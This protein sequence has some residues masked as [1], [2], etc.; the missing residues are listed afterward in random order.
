MVSNVVFAQAGEEI[1][2]G[3]NDNVKHI[4]IRFDHVN[5]GTTWF[6]SSSLGTIR[7]RSQ[8]D[9]PD[10]ADWVLIP[11][12]NKKEINGSSYEGYRIWNANS[13]LF[14][15]EPEKTFQS[16]WHDAEDCSYTAKSGFSYADA[17]EFWIVPSRNLVSYFGETASEKIEEGWWDGT[18]CLVTDAPGRQPNDHCSNEFA[19]L[20][21]GFVECC[22]LPIPGFSNYYFGANCLL[23][24]TESESSLLEDF[25][26][27]HAYYSAKNVEAGTVP[28]TFKAEY[29][30]AFRQVLAEAGEVLDDLDADISAANIFRI[31][32]EI[33]SSYLDM[34][35]N[36]QNPIPDGYYRFVSDAVGV[37]TSSHVSIASRDE[38]LYWKSDDVFDPSQIWSVSY[39]SNT[40]YYNV[41][42]ALTG[43]IIA[44]HGFYLP[45]TLDQ[46][47]IRHS[48]R[49]NRVDLYS[50]GIPHESY[51]GVSHYLNH[52][53]LQ[54]TWDVFKESYVDLYSDAPWQLVSVSQRELDLAL[55]QP[56]YKN[57]MNEA[58]NIVEGVHVKNGDFSEASFTR[59]ENK[60]LLQDW[61]I[62]QHTGNTTEGYMRD[63]TYTN[64]DATLSGFAEYWLGWALNNGCI[65]QTLNG[66]P[67]GTY[68]LEADMIAANEA[69]EEIHGVLLFASVDAK[70]FE[71]NVSTKYN[72]PEHFVL[73]FTVDQNRT[74]VTVG[75]KMEGTNAV[76]AAI[77]N[78][79]LTCLES[80]AS[81]YLKSKV[82]Y[83]E[84]CALYGNMKDITV[85]T[86]SDIDAL[87]AALDSYNAE[88]V[89]NYVLADGTVLD[90]V[91]LY[92]NQFTYTRKFGTT[93]WQSL[94]VPAEIPVSS[95]DK[96]GLRA[97]YINA[98]HQ[99]DTDGDNVPDQLTMEIFY[100]NK[101]TLFANHP[102]M[103]R[104][105]STGEK[106]I[107]ANNVFVE[108]VEG[109]SI[110]CSSTT[111][112]YTVTGRYHK[113]PADELKSNGY[114]IM[115]GGAFSQLSASSTATLGAERWF[116]NIESRGAQY[117]DAPLP[118][119]IKIRAI[120][121]DGSV[122]ETYIN[123]IDAADV[124]VNG[125][126]YDVMGRRVQNATKGIYI[127]NGKKMLR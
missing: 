61:S 82:A 14:L 60:S 46:L 90:G 107:V 22:N 67:S 5:R 48:E 32:S 116:L 39:D 41:K 66:L 40:G 76:W 108:T 113:T 10:Y 115:S 24:I 100:I 97:A 7:Q 92:A 64:G 106:T 30:N 9:A 125:A 45:G 114:Y 101:G 105:T 25:R 119:S 78:V 120:D 85:A 26:K 96:Q 77:D 49:G 71:Q 11:T 79:Q 20:D 88:Y 62:R 38:V 29:V 87:R 59:I 83:R 117:M 99:Y 81:D 54:D 13:A 19:T 4:Q 23:T 86:Q 37:A 103:I 8:A 69:N 33:N 55:L 42:N 17:A 110:D 15:S 27:V 95:L 65:S 84:L 56:T 36:G 50:L 102:Y 47:A 111:Y 3:I 70:S 93:S 1:S 2:V 18:Y 57:L 104:A 91:A 51:P 109:G 44:D 98:F 118:K 31:T 75:M 6:T 72:L 12:G 127:Q 94:Y 89:D 124:D 53:H 123:T 34:V 126:L 112:K 80:A 16:H 68:R 21:Y 73:E 74:D 52:G 35:L 63:A 121:E 58:S 43:K 122:E 28:G